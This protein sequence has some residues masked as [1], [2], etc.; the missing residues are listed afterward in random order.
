[1]LGA[2]SNIPYENEAIANCFAGVFAQV[3]EKD[4]SLGKGDLDEA[5]FGL[6]AAGDPTP[7]FTGNRRIDRQIALRVQYLGHGTREQR[8]DNFTRGYKGGARAC[9][10][11]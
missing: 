2:T 8:L 6:A 3:S 7:Q 4:G 1:Q 9:L 10:S 5:F 11:S